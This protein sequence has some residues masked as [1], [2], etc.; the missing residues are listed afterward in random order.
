MALPCVPRIAHAC[1]KEEKTTDKGF[2]FAHNIFC[3]EHKVKMERKRMKKKK[4]KLKQQKMKLKE[5][6]KGIE[7]GETKISEP[8]AWRDVQQRLL[9]TTRRQK[10]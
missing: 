6:C 4:K 8:A 1:A 9:I 3:N 10:Q 2:G 7:E 5:K